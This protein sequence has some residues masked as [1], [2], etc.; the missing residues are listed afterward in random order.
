M[1]SMR[2]AFLLAIAA[3][4]TGNRDVASGS[5]SPAGSSAATTGPTAASPAPTSDA[6]GLYV[7]ALS[8]APSFCCAHPEKQECAG[9]ADAFGATHL[10]LHGLWPNYTD[11]EAAQHHTSYPQFCGTYDHCKK[12]HDRS[13][14]PDPAA[15]PRDM[16]E[17]GPGYVGDH[18]FLADHEWPKHGS[19]TKLAPADY[20]RAALDAMKAIPTPENVRAAVGHDLALADLEGAF[21][22]PRE[23]VLLS[24][25]GQCRL[26][27]VSFCLSHDA[28]DRPTTPVACPTNTTRARYDN[29]CV[30]RHCERVTIPAV[31]DCQVSDRPRK[32]MHRDGGHPACNHPGQGPPCTDND[33]C[34]RAGYTR[35]ARS[36]CCTSQP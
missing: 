23:S 24:C 34:V 29:G 9:L 30:T 35:C 17:L 28:R 13:C 36:G 31:G 19:C 3:C 16:R 14:E 10:T 26:Q 20:F 21:G 33:I 32:N 2:I 6:F 4:E 1:A 22:V 15:I 25:D 11:D 5:A 7:L 12:D 18:E 27:Q 8:W